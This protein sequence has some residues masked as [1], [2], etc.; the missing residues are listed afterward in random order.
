MEVAMKSYLVKDLMVL[1]SEYATVS[2]DASLFEAVLALEKAQENFEDKHTR[3]RHR[4]ILILDK[5]GQVVGKLSQLDVLRALEPRYQEMIQGEGL[6]RFGFSKEFEKSIL[7]DYHLFA[8]PL[9]DLCRKAG[10]QG[11][12]VYSY[13]RRI[14]I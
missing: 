12:Y 14:C 8:N 4:A 5:D 9:D 7:E 13:Q 3:Y 11:I 10:R 2:E 1:L 6:H